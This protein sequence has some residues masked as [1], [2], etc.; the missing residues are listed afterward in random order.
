[1]RNE[2]T[3]TQTHTNYNDIANKDHTSKNK[4]TQYNVH[5][6]PG[7]SP[8]WYSTIPELRKSEIPYDSK[9]MISSP[10]HT[11]PSLEICAYSMLYPSFPSVKHR[12]DHDLVRVKHRVDH[13]LVRVKH[14]VVERC[15]IN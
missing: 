12:V 6:I 8:F 3:H 9:K 10:D 11:E 13:D 2:H 4:P 5:S 15:S 7:Q 1:M 14:R